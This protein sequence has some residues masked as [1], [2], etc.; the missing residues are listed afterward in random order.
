[1]YLSQHNRHR[2]WGSCC[3]GCLRVFM[4]TNSLVL[5]FFKQFYEK[6]TDEHRESIYL[7]V[8]DSIGEMT[9]DTG[10]LGFFHS[11]GSRK[12][13]RDDILYECTEILFARNYMFEIAEKHAYIRK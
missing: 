11:K 4:G 8:L 9:S 13:F 7:S 5:I 2:Q 6:Y 12:N 1:M 10:R 3:C